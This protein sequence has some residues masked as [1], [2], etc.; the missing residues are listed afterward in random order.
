[1]PVCLRRS[2]SLRKA[3]LP[4]LELFVSDYPDHQLEIP[5]FAR[6]LSMKRTA[7]LN[8]QLEELTEGGRN[9][10]VSPALPGPGFIP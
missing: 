9:R 10:A 4:E 3:R 6:L 7:Y 1:M 2:I 5:S 8:R